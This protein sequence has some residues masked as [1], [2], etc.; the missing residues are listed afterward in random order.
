MNQTHSPNTVSIS[1]DQIEDHLDSTII[2]LANVLKVERSCD[3]DEAIK[4][5]RYRLIKKVLEF[6]DEDV[7][8]TINESIQEIRKRRMKKTAN[9]HEIKAHKALS[10]F[11]STE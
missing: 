9:E 3:A 1:S 4:E 8:T 5:I 10:K 6:T 2:Q 11:F 7:K